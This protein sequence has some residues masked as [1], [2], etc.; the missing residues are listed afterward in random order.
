MGPNILTMHLLESSVAVVLFLIFG[1]S[2]E[3]DDEVARD[4]DAVLF[5]VPV[6]PEKVC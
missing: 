5:V 6:V 2:T 3:T 4:S 1:S